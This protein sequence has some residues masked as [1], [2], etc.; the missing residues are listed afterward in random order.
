[1]PVREPAARTTP[2]SAPRR[3]RQPETVVL[4]YVANQMFAI[5][6]DAVQEIRSTDSLA[7]SAI[8]IDQI[9]IGKVRHTVERGHRTYF[10]LNAGMH[11]GLPVTRPTLVLILRKLRVAVLID[12]IE[13]MAEIYGVHPLPLA[14][15]GDE[16]R[17]YRGLAQIDDLVIPVIRP[18]GFLSEEEFRTLDLAA[19]GATAKPPLEG[20]AS[21]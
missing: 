12:R 2:K 1:M 4:F 6:A 15:A 9:E 8:E 16:R 7:G 21:T 11:F 18:D 17:W 19:Q 13:R 5:A 10:V 20:T 14:F 3:A